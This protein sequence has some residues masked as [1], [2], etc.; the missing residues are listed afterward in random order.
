VLC[1]FALSIFKEEHI[2]MRTR[3]VSMSFAALTAA[4][5]I[6]LG[7]VPKLVDEAAWLWLKLGDESGDDIDVVSL[8]PLSYPWMILS[9]PLLP[10]SSARSSTPTMESGVG[11]CEPS[12][13]STVAVLPSISGRYQ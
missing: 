7:L 3:T 13:A 12:L 1:A 6:D 10:S 8:S 9:L 5:D 4:P 2:C 11:A